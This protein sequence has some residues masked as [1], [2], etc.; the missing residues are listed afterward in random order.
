[1]RGGKRSNSGRPR[2]AQ[3]KRTEAVQAAT[4]QV[5]EQIEVVLPDAF[6]G[7]AHAYLM[8]I[9]KDPAQ[10][11]GLRVD[12]AKAA[13]R[14]EKPSMAPADATPK[15]DAV[16]LIDRVKEWEREEAIVGSAGKVV[17]LRR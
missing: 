17:E 11:T 6:T 2:G 7:D 14:Y 10:P 15:T 13:I 3:N 1:M 4:Q 16:P 12:A 8:A 5:A 9:Y